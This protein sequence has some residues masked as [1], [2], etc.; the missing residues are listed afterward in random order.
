MSNGEAESA[1][2]VMTILLSA[3]SGIAGIVA[4]AAGFTRARARKDKDFDDRLRKQEV[5]CAGVSAE[6]LTRL[7]ALDTLQTEQNSKLD[8]QK[9]GI[10]YL[11]GWARNG[12]N[13]DADE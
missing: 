4:T 8:K 13:I 10:D 9:K 3:A 6:V 7:D 2:S 1:S 11:V 5:K 12:G